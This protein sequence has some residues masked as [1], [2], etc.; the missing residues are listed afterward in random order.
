M[1]LV[2]DHVVPHLALEN[3]CVPTRKCVRGDANVEVVLIVPSLSQF[4]PTLGAAVITQGLEAGEKLLELH[5]PVQQH[6]RWN[7]LGEPSVIR[8]K[9][10]DA[11]KKPPDVR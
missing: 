9:N 5:L 7:D 8:F 3:V 6:A 1:C 4:F 2:Q 11:P 10:E